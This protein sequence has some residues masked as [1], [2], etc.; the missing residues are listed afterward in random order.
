MQD[1]G[2]SITGIANVMNS[3]A[4]RW[5][6]VVYK[7][8]LISGKVN[9]VAYQPQYV[10]SS[11]SLVISQDAFYHRYSYDAE[12]RITIVETSADST[13]WEK[14][15]RYYYYKHGPLARSIIGKQQ[16]Q[17]IDYAYTL[18]GWL[19]GVNST[20]ITSAL[21]MG[22]DDDQNNAATK[23]TALDA[24]GFNL[25]YFNGDYTTIG[26][27]NPFAPVNSSGI[28]SATDYRPLYNGNI[29]SMAVNIRKFNSV[30][31]NGTAGD[32]ALL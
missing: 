8:D 14:D 20:T 21:D 12:N 18:Q 6:R 25:N 32:S 17:G 28:L 22:N 11:G 29:S 4:S 23:F 9:Q 30:T 15:A 3:N 16:V 2:Q 13:I 19:K 1:Y 26:G 31:Q 7:Y 10:N 5:K 27:I 24:Y